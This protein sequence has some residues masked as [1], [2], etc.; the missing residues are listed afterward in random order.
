MISPQI[1]RKLPCR[2]FI[3][4]FSLPLLISCSGPEPTY[5]PLQSGYKWRYDVAMTTRD[6]LE[7]QKYILNNLGRSELNAEPVYARQSLDGTL[8]YYA[9]ENDEIRYLGSDSRDVPGGEFKPDQQIVM[10]QPL[11]LNAKWE[12]NSQTRLLKKTGP[13]QKTEFRI[14][15]RVPLE[16]TVDSLSD[17]VRVPAGIF[18]NCLKIRMT[19]SMMK[20]AG[21]YVGMTLINVEETRWYAPGIGL[22]KLER[23]ETTQS[24][25][26][27]RGSLLVELADYDVG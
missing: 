7:N 10:K 19:G 24:D 15:A 8:L 23:L 16:V 6:G 11:E 4:I 1:L 12:A 2:L 26:L 22:V 25:A 17:T 18:S 21:N 13:P 5:F 27:D 20:D 3:L 9:I 14:V